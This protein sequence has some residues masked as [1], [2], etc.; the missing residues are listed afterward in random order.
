MQDAL[1]SVFC[2]CCTLIQER[3]EI[4]AEEQ[5]LNQMAQ[6]GETPTMYTDADVPV[7]G[8]AGFAV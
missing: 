1:I 4:E 5:Y 7:E 3:R 6:Q 2:T 8:D